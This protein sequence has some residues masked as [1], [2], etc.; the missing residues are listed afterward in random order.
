ME[1]TSSFLN[2]LNF[3]E[4]R[5][6]SL[7]IKIKSFLNLKYSFCRPLFR[8]LDYAARGDR[9]TRP[10][11]TTPLAAIRISNKQALCL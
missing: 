3:V 6:S 2:N 11:L 10:S 7:S 1:F 8:P 5:N 4:R 9:T